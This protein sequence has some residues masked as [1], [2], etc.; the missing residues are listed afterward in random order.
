MKGGVGASLASSGEV[1]VGALAVVNAFGDVR[2][3]AGRI[4]AG[5]RRDG[6]FLDAA[7]IL[8]ERSDVAEFGDAGMR[9][10]TLA[11]VIASAPMSRVELHQLAH[12]AS[13]ALLRRI[14]PAGTTFDGDVVFAMA[15]LTGRAAPA[16]QLE[17]L[18]VEALEAAIERGVTTA[19]GRDGLPGLAD[20]AI[21]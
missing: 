11:V 14:T 3:R 18:A 10:T 15:P 19:R 2:D 17:V 9:N 1:S 4:I 7:R 21:S 6:Q 12:A 5:A 13:A 8:R 20:Q 16:V